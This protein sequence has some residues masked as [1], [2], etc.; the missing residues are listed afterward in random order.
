MPDALAADYREFA[1]RYYRWAL[2]QW[3]LEIDG[4]FPLLRTLRDSA[5]TEVLEIMKT[6]SRDERLEMALILSK[7][8]HLRGVEALGE[9]FSVE[10]QRLWEHWRHQR[11]EIRRNSTEA[12]ALSE[13]RKK[14]IA[15][16]RAAIRQV[17][18]PLL[19]K[20]VENCHGALYQYEVPIGRFTVATRIDFTGRWNDFYYDHLIRRT[21]DSFHFPRSVS[22]EQ[23]FGIVGST[24][25]EGLSDE[26][27]PGAVDTLALVC[28]RFLEAAPHLLP[29]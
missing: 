11:T 14:R 9:T 3:R 6:M 19:G 21:E 12:A 23:W 18:V 24:Q 26:D 28:R 20:E 10:E 22:V 25:W 17:V 8:Q 29:E 1:A 4:G 5:C 15:P 16:F 13:L 7:R 2:E 27:I